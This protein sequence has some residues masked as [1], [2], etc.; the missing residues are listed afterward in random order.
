[1]SSFHSSNLFDVSGKVVL[2][3]GGSRGIGKMIVQG[4]VANGAKVYISSRS[5]KDC[6][7]TAAEL[8]ASGP[9]TCIALPADMQKLEQ[10]EELLRTLT[11]REH[12]LH[13]L[14]NNAGA[15]WGDPIDDY[16]DSAFTKLL[17]LNAQRVFTLT[18]K[19]LPLL[20]A[21]AEQGGKDGDV[22]RDPARIINIGSVE[23][24]I[25]PNHETYAYSASKAALHHLS[26]HLAGRLGWEGITSNT[27]ACGPFESK[28]MAHTLDTQGEII[29]KLI[30]LQ[31]I[32]TP[33][34]VAGTALFLASR[35]GAFVNG[36]TITVDGGQTVGMRI[37][38][39][40]ARL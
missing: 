9:G 33:V 5:A 24:L 34:D 21:A 13:V 22:F 8:N 15:A 36:A 23:G 18:Q 28:M 16:P 29:K 27:I 3:T 35:A 19:C 37:M 32:G 10:V 40:L 20:R 14:V 1:M 12:A 25:V 39:P 7:A 26:R 11:A 4:F 31:R 30:P 2:V 38:S 17:T 6:E